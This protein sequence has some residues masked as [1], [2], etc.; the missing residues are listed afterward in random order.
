MV[1]IQLPLRR[2]GPVKAVSPLRSPSCLPRAINSLPSSRSFSKNVRPSATLAPNLS[3]NDRPPPAV[4]TNQ[5][6]VLG[7]VPGFRAQ[8]MKVDLDRV[9]D[10]R[11]VSMMVDYAKSHGNLYARAVL[12][13]LREKPNG[14][15]ASPMPTVMC[16]STGE[17]TRVPIFV[18]IAY[19]SQLCPNRLHPRGLQQHTS[20]SHG[21][22]PRD[23]L[24]NREQTRDWK[25]SIN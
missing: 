2:A 12:H 24:L 8:E 13:H 19:Q 5:P 14:W 18:Y 3:Y 11:S 20:Y 6:S 7:P 25:L 21:T 4:P 23:D 16:F 22:K 9:F 17:Q 10:T 15:A 1:Q